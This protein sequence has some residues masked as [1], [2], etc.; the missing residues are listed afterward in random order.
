VERYELV[1]GIDE[2][3]MLN[4]KVMIGRNPFQRVGGIQNRQTALDYFLFSPFWDKNCNNELFYMQTA[5]RGLRQPLE[6]TIEAI[7]YVANIIHSNIY[8]I[9]AFLF[10]F[11]VK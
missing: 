4:I 9:F 1:D 6:K 8:L 7:R 11:L 2:Y 10:F 3:Q 5:Y